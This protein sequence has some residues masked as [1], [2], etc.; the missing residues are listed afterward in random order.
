MP[1]QHSKALVIS[2]FW[3]SI[4]AAV[5]GTGILSGIA[6]AVNLNSDTQVLKNQMQA[7]QTANVPERL[8]KLETKM[9]EIKEGQ[10]AQSRKLDYLIQ[11][12]VVREEEGRHGR[13]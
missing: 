5:L 7:V 1:G 2:P 8:A 6:F 3:A 12:R 13:P 10:A 9:D 11:T 4:M